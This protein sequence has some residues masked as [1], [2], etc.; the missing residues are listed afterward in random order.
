MTIIVLFLVLP[1]IILAVAFIY[2]GHVNRRCQQEDD[3]RAT[4]EPLIMSCFADRPDIIS[5]LQPETQSQRIQ[6]LQT[7]A[8]FELECG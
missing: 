2:C 6:R 1:A 3:S 7:Q 5:A 8:D 4:P